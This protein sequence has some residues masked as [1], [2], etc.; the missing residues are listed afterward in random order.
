MQDKNT[1]QTQKFSSYVP[2]TGF[3]PTFARVR[4]TSVVRDIVQTRQ[5]SGFDLYKRIF[6]FRPVQ[7]TLCVVLLFVLGSIFILGPLHT[8][9][10]FA[11]FY[12][13]HCLGTWHNPQLASGQTTQPLESSAP[14]TITEAN[15][16]V[17][18]GGEKQLFCG[19]FPVVLPGDA[20]IE[21]LKLRLA[22]TKQAE[23]KA[24]P[25]EE[26]VQPVVPSTTPESV[27]GP[28]TT[29]ASENLLEGPE[30]RDISSSTP[31]TP[32]PVIPKEEPL[33]NL[34]PSSSTHEPTS[35]LQRLL[36]HAAYAEEPLS[37]ETT[38]VESGNTEAVASSTPVSTSTTEIPATFIEPSTQSNV[39]SDTLFTIRYSLDGQ[40]WQDVGKVTDKL[41]SEFDIQSIPL[42]Q[43]PNVQISIESFQNTP[44]V[45]LLDGLALVIKYKTEAEADG[46]QLPDLSKGLV[47]Y[48]QV[49]G[50]L[51]VVE[52]QDADNQQTLWVTERS[53]NT[54]QWR[55]IADPTS[56]MRLSPVAT[57][58]T[59]VVWLAPGGDALMGYIFASQT[60][61]SQT[62]SYDNN[63]QTALPLAE[64][65]EVSFDGR[66]F[67]FSDQK[68]GEQLAVPLQSSQ[69]TFNQLVSI[70]P[71][72]ATTTQEAL[73]LS[74]PQVAGTS[75][76]ISTTSSSEE[77]QVPT[78]LEKSTHESN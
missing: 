57:N 36:I 23:Q 8:S 24:L 27:S 18:N 73:P 19:D 29:P 65:A 77:S 42:E 6:Y 47:L 37:H 31:E 33:P 54:L 51:A 40:A 74:D 76:D 48:Q 41:E 4:L 26:V 55:K 49:V 71:I 22:W 7:I 34:E 2:R 59:A 9:A 44:G 60:Y 17:F 16:A 52:F 69:E 58:G 14:A 12:P 53:Q 39:A 30:L 62:M 13:K 20:R 70:Q 72:P 61:V 78:S 45:I 3:T 50:S 46:A 35:F 28:T 67:S 15:S 75:T 68:T 10:Q 32:V 63:V 11:Y 66:Q 38:T 1:K 56:M 43:L 5:S 64:G 25:T 21:D